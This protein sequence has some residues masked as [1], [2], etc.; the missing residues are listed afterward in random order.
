MSHV[1]LESDAV[2]DPVFPKVLGNHCAKGLSQLI[3]LKLQLPRALL[4]R[5]HLRAL[6]GGMLSI[7]LQIVV[8]SRKSTKRRPCSKL[9]EQPEKAVLPGP[10]LAGKVMKGSQLLPEPTRLTAAVPSFPSDRASR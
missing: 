8:V 6:V 4:F 3:P 2:Q 7:R 9:A 10:L 1:L 5:D